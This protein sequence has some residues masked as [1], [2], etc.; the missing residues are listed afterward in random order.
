MQE[1]HDFTACPIVGS[2]LAGYF[3]CSNRDVDL[4]GEMDFMPGFLNRFTSSF[5]E[6]FVSL[7]NC[8]SSCRRF[9]RM[10]INGWDSQTQSQ[11]QGYPAFDNTFQ[12]LT[13]LFQGLS[14]SPHDTKLWKI[15]I[16]GLFVFNDLICCRGQRRMNVF[17][18]HIEFLYLLQE[19]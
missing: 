18:E 12:V 5:Q 14:D 13:A 8:L 6:T 10:P 1:I 3:S 2:C 9:Y 4:C 7:Y 15:S 16:K 19:I 17:A 11:P